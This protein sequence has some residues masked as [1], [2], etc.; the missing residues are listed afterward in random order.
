MLLVRAAW[1]D[2]FDPPAGYYGGATGSGSALKSQ[3]NAI[4][5]TGHTGISYDSL[6]TALQV[7]DA[8]PNNPGRMLL[9]YDRV[10]L[11]VAAIN[12]GGPIPGW[13]EGAS[14]NREHTWPVSRGLGSESMPDGSDLHHLRP[15]TPSVNS[16]RGNQN[17]GGAFGQ[18]FGEV[19]DG[20]SQFWYPGD[21][22]AGM[23]ARSQLYMAVRY[24]GTDPGTVDLELGL[25]NTPDMPGNTDPPPQLGNL[26]RMIEWHFAAPPDNFERRRHQIVFDSYQHNRNPFID[27]PE[28]V[29]S[30]F[31]DQANDSRV[32]IGGATVGSNGGSTRQVDFGRTFVGGAVPAAQSFTLHK[33]SNDGTYFR[34][35]TAGVATSSLSGRFNAFRTGG[36]DTQNIAV[37]LNTSTAT[38]GLKTGTVTIDNLDITGGGGVGRGVND[39]NDVFD[40]SLAVLDHPV[41]SYSFNVERRERVIDFG[42]V[43]VGSGPISRASSFLSFDGFGSP[44]F[45]ANLDL[46]AI[47]GLGDTDVFQVE[48]EP[49][50][51]LEQ[52]E[53]VAFDSSFLPN[54]I[55][56][57][58]ATY[59]LMLSDEDLPGEQT[60]TLTLSLR[61]EAILSGD[62]NRDATVDAADYVVWRH[63]F[64]EEVTAYN[65]ADGDGDGTIDDGDYNVW[66]A[67]FGMSAP[68]ASLLT[69]AVPEP[70][71]AVLILSLLLASGS[72]NCGR[73]ARLHR[74]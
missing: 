16:D 74:R 45:A 23:I 4:V 64:G 13:D 62:Y 8:D 41:A 66:R 53:V 20:Q 43:P 56:Q 14:W 5:K 58:A 49:F 60:Q 37:G 54:A 27:R 65:S 50:A 10:S 2:A 32:S 17:F 68:G 18:P 30:V 72:R 19:I 73:W 15:S 6:R 34:V 33:T 67:N 71:T 51:G 11:N 48:L 3:L 40:V 28:F 7:T 57:F 52:G 70:G 36:P 12:P 29:W 9:V 63:A 44:E 1:A 39:A 21:A 22:D 42:I 31:V 59:R 55:G 47:A 69:R 24:D 26:E 61:A 38:S 46:D 35:T 25:G